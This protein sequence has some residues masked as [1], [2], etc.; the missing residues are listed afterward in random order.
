MTIEKKEKD[1]EPKKR[2]RPKRKRR[3]GRPRK[4]GPKRKRRV[5]KPKILKKR[6]PE[7]LPEIKYKI[8]SCRNGKQNKLIGKY[9]NIEDAY[10]K[11]NELKKNDDKVIFPSFVTGVNRLENSIDE[12]VIIEKNSKESSVLRNEY[13][14]LI[15]HKT[16][17][18]GWTIIDKYRYLREETFWV[19]GYDKKKE[20]KTFMW[21]LSNIILNGIETK[22]DHKN[23][24]T[25]KNKLIIKDSEGYIDI[26][27][28]KNISDAIRFYNMVERYV[29]KHKYKQIFFIGDFSTFNEKRKK[30]ENEL[31]ELTGWTLRK[32]RMKNSSFFNK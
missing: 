12:Y 3:V 26:V 13:G 11:F 14:K 29:K 7:K 20:R 28:C 1:K 10:I 17:Q 6:G 31:V 24:L 27:F 22:Y 18:E 15:E 8:I 9:R 21:I 5:K 32:I 4:R 19:F 2:K 23:I 30:L 16:N 25:Y